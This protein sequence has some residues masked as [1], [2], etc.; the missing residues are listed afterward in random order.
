MEI[1]QRTKKYS[2][3]MIDRLWEEHQTEMNDAFRH[4]EDGLKLT[5]VVDIMPGKAGTNSVRVGIG[6]TQ[7]KVKSKTDPVEINEDQ[8]PL[9]GGEKDAN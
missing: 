2:V 1:G 9:F 6:F 4:A 8:I 7:R 3:E 5:F